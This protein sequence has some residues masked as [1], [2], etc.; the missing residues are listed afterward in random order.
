MIAL[1]SGSDATMA[2]TIYARHSYGPEDLVRDHRFVDVLYLT[3]KGERVV[4][5]TRFHD[6]E[7]IEP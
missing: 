6:T 2:E 3:P 5:L 1:L 4:D 7:L